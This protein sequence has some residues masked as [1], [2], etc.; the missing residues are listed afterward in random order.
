MSD[1]LSRRRILALGAITTSLMGGAYTVAGLRSDEDEPRAD[2]LRDDQISYEHDNIE[3]QVIQDTV[4]IGDTIEFEVTNT[5]ESNVTLGCQNPWTVEKQENG[6][7]QTVAW[8]GGDYYKLCA[9][10]LSPGET[11]TE[12]L[13]LSKS[14]LVQRAD[15]TKLEIRPGQYR[16]VLLGPSP[17]YAVDFRVLDSE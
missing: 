1:R 3:V 6:E 7:W 12:S 14:E 2:Y 10:V 8:T 16:F 5:G 4:Y 9:T 17:F 13:S 11:Y 15:N